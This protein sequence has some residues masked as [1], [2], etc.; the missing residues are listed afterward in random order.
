MEEFCTWCVEHARLLQSKEARGIYNNSIGTYLKHLR[1]L[2]KFAD[3][4]FDWVEDDF[5]QDV[6]REA[7]TY[8]EVMQ[9]CRHE[10]LEL[11]EGSTNYL[12]RRVVRDL[13]V[14]NCLMGPRY[15]NL[16]TLKPS[17]VVLE[18]MT[19]PDTGESWQQPIIEY[20]Q[21]KN[22][23]QLR[24]IRVAL[25]PV[26]YE[27]WQ[28]YEGKLSMPA[29]VTMNAQIKT[30]CRAAGLK[31]TVTHVRGSGAE[32]IETA[33][34]LWQAVSCHTARYTFVTL[35]YE[36]ST[37]IVFIQDSVG[38]ASLTT[39]RK[40][41]KTRLKERLASTLNAFDKLREWDAQKAQ[42]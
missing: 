35:Q 16:A 2:L 15:G 30:L 3:L 33:I 12:S 25:D 23:R 14:F 10:P 9:I 22:R 19:N 24:K 1:K 40:Y 5:S 41:L 26:A 32:R 38:H 21:C 8:A 29:N 27:I 13:F 37:G 4:K 36:G 42:E 39:T 20:V 31:R 28:R 17:D 34:P 11:K 7:L 6:D 18:T